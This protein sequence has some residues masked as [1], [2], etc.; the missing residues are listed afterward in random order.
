MN[1]RYICRTLS[2][3]LVLFLILSTAI[4]G[5]AIT[6]DEEL[7]YEDLFSR[8][9]ED[10]PVVPPGDELIQLLRQN[11][12]EF[13]GQLAFRDLLTQEAVISILKS[14]MSPEDCTAIMETLGTL[15]QGYLVQQGMIWVFQYPSKSE[16][17]M[18]KA[19]LYSCE[20]MKYTWAEEYRNDYSVLFSE[21]HTK[22]DASYS[23]ELSWDLATSLKGDPVA[24]IRNLSGED[25]EIQSKVSDRLNYHCYTA[26]GQ[27]ISDILAS[28]Q[29]SEE[30]SESEKLTAVFLYGKMQ[31]L[32]AGPVLPTGPDPEELALRSNGD[33]PPPTTLPEETV[34]AETT[35]PTTVPE[36]TVP[37][38]AAPETKET[39]ATAPTVLPSEQQ[40]PEDR[41]NGTTLVLTVIGI[42]AI[43]SVVIL[44]QW[45]KKF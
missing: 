34:P 25:E 20:Y 24:F 31:P 15:S 36:T 23:E 22:T 21:V 4:C 29:N 40:V 44:V 3:F 28:V 43:T 14:A 10:Q 2:L 41:K 7:Y 42:V 38:T 30:L 27:V 39:Q 8:V 9:L 5:Y 11:A 1:K 35:V 17:N 19:I 18:L 26:F 37:V 45:R 6:E 13:I 32:L 16:E 33:T 12:E